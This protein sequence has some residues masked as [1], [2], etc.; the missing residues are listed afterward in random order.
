[1]LRPVIAAVRRNKRSRVMCVVQWDPEG[2]SRLDDMVVE[3][4]DVYDISPGRSVPVVSDARASLLLD[5]CEPDS[6]APFVTGRCVR[7]SET[8]VDG[9][10]AGEKVAQTRFGIVVGA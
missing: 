7:R 6:V 3:V 8:V 9:E 10:N 2:E 4:L 1:M 5:A